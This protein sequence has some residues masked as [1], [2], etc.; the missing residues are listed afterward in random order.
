MTEWAGRERRETGLVGSKFGALPCWR[1]MQRAAGSSLRRWIDAHSDLRLLPNPSGCHTGLQPAL[2]AGRPMVLTL[3]PSAA[4]IRRPQAASSPAAASSSAAR[5][6][7][8]RP[9]AAARRRLQRAA[10]EKEG[11]ATQQADGEQLR[12]PDTPPAP[13]GAGAASSSSSAQQQPQASAASQLNQVR[14][15][16][17]GLSA[18]VALPLLC[19]PFVCAY[20]FVVAA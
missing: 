10:A 19:G 3:C 7:A 9:A 4:G 17:R 11:G 1:S 6:H 14:A 18:L 20:A 2:S 15:W 5:L 8:A 12:V 16:V 13:A